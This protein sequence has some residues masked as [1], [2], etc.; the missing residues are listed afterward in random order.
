MS[1]D[2]ARLNGMAFAQHLGMVFVRAS[3]GE[4]VVT[5]EVAARHGNLRGQLHGGIMPVVIDAAGSVAI[6]STV[7]EATVLT[8]DLRV[9]FVAPVEAGDRVEA[10]GRIAH[11]GGGT[12]F[13]SVVVRNGRGEV[14]ALGQVTG[15]IKRGA[16]KGA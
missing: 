3:E 16:A 6:W 7:P 4:A 10:V 2:L 9:N 5:L 12:G 1:L 8:A 13:A 15:I 14:V 11:G